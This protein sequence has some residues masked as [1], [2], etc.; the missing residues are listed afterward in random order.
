MDLFGWFGLVVFCSLWIRAMASGMGRR[1]LSDLH[2]AS[3]ILVESGYWDIVL[4]VWAIFAIIAIL[5]ISM[6]RSKNTR[7]GKAPSSSVERAVKKRKSDTSQ[8]IKKGKGK[9]RESSFESEEVSESE[10]EEIEAMFAEAS[11]SE[12]EKWAQS[13]AKRGF[14]YERG[15]KLDTFLYSHPIRGVIQEHNLQ[16]VCTEV[17]G[18][19]P[20]LVREFYTN[21]R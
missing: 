2:R 15:V 1:F 10:D 9:R 11:E 5:A 12:Q 16:F 20:T 18:Y 6:A 14:H 4:C 19:L 7:K 13:I 21:L 3:P 17:Q 8:P